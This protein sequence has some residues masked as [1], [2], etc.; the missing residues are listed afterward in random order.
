M[1]SILPKA[2]LQMMDSCASCSPTIELSTSTHL[3]IIDEV[4]TVSKDLDTN[5]CFTIVGPALKATKKER[6][7]NKT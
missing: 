3:A 2:N 7:E 5:S 6:N 4:S 1:S